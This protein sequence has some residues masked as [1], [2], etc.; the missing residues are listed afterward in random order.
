MKTKDD[1]FTAD[2]FGKV[3]GRPRKP[4]A[5]TVAQRVRKHRAKKRISVTG[6]E[7][8]ADPAANDAVSCRLI[9][10]GTE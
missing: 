9:L 7:K 2:M 4:N 5:M 8:S 6:N 10:K 1:K 3:R